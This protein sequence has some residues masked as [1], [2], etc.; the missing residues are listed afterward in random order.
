MT[1]PS[2]E[3]PPHRRERHALCALFIQ[4]GPDAP[5]LCEGWATR[6]LAAHLV[7]R[8][9]NPVAA[10]GIAVP[11]LADSH[12]RALRREAARHPYEELVATVDEGPPPWWKPLDRAVNL[13]EFVVHH[14]DVRRGREGWS[15]RPEAE[16]AD[17]ERLVWKGFRRGAFLL[18]RKTKGVTVEL[19]RPDGEATTLRGHGPKV[20][21]RG[22][23]IELLLYL[24]GRR[25]AAEVELSGSD[26]ALTA[27]AAADLSA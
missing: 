4:V 13:V 1:P 15:P 5:T 3:Q 18:A 26:A 24:M 6:Q 22:R 20:V 14:E 23:P 2:P 7:V 25:G 19:R 17:I 27:L 10:A 21:M 12:E 11:A 16:V 8:E 9:H